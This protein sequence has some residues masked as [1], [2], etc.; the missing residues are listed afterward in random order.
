MKII[1]NHICTSTK[2]LQISGKDLIALGCPTGAA[3]GDILDTLLDEVLKD[4][5]KNNKIDLERRALDLI[6]GTAQ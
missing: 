3:I 5:E 6:S 1:E 4:P 2:E